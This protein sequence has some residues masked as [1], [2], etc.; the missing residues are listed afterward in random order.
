[1]NICNNS[2]E[3]IFTIF[4]F[5]IKFAKNFKSRK[6]GKQNKKKHQKLQFFVENIMLKTTFWKNV[7]VKQY[8]FHKKLLNEKILQKT[9]KLKTEK[10]EKNNKNCIF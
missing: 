4:G 10:I 5:A 9:S 8:F 1:M 3:M 2:N 7:L 6:K